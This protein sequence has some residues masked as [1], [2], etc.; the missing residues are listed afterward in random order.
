MESFRKV[1]EERQ[2]GEIKAY[3]APTGLNP[4]TRVRL[5]IYLSF[6]KG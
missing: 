4:G 1:K 5:I 3:I 2:I 6:R